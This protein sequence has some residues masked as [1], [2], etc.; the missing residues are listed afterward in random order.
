MTDR[1]VRVSARVRSRRPRSA[2]GRAR[3]RP[4]R[5]RGVGDRRD[6]HARALRRRERSRG[7]PCCV[8]RRRG[9]AGRAGLGGRLARI[10]PSGARRRALDRAAVGAARRRRARRRDRSGPCVRHRRA[11]DD[12]ALR[13]AARHVGERIAARR[14]LWIGRAVDRG[15]AARVR[16]D[17]G[18]RQR[19]GRSRDDDRQCRGQRRRG[20]RDGARRRGGRAAGRGPGR[21]ERAARS[22]GED[23]RA[24]RTRFAITSG[25]LD[26]DPAAPGWRMSSGSSSTAGPRTGSSGAANGRPGA[27]G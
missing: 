25:Y 27:T 20:R 17:Q 23:P 21:C 1:F 12:A 10:S 16:A 7:D 9:D 22:G 11:S 24:A 8:R 18:R 2:R 26:G 19:S 13:R 14:R 6:A 15:R 4:R 5:V 3:T